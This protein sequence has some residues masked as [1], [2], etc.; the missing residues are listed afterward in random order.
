MTY[1]E[2]ASQ[3]DKPKIANKPAVQ[4]ASLDGRLAGAEDVRLIFFGTEDFSVPALES[5]LK[6]GW[7]VEAVVTKPDVKAGRGQKMRS[8][9]IKKIAKNHRLS[10]LQPASLVHFHNELSAL[11]PSHGVLVSYGK[12]IPDSILNLFPGG[13]INV[14]PSLLPS[15]RGP[16]P[17]EAAILNGDARTGISLIKLTS[18]MDEG[19]IYAQKTLDLGHD[20]TRPDLYSRLAD[21]GAKFLTDKFPQIVEGSLSPTSQNDKLATYTKLLKKADG[22]VNW[23]ESSEVIA[24]KVRAYLGYPKS[25]AKLFGHNI[26]ITK[27]RVASGPGDGKL[28]IKCRPGWLEVCE[29]IAPSGRAMSGGDFLRGYKESKG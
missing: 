19:P 1:D 3:S 6:Q 5:L 28:L 17:I 9:R 11:E 13:I 15:Y 14:H 12:I 25:S 16:S 23:Q 24:R 8:P 20:E 7:Q 2:R 22:Q 27:A 4:P 18:G 26:I 29:L 10:L 21:L